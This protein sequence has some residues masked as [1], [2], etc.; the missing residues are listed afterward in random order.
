MIQDGLGED[1]G[2][3]EEVS[4]DV[5]GET[6]T[7]KISQ[8]VEAKLIVRRIWQ[9]IGDSDSEDNAESSDESSESEEDDFKEQRSVVSVSKESTGPPAKK[10]GENVEGMKTGQAGQ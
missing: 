8:Q 2:N 10:S 7:E 1:D 6:A 3:I 9:E 5:Q 4:N